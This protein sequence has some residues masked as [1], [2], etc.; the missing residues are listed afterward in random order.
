MSKLPFI[1][2]PEKPFRK[3]EGDFYE[4]LPEIDAIS[5]ERRTICEADLQEF[6]TTPGR[7]ALYDAIMDKAEA[8]YEQEMI[9]RIE[10]RNHND[11]MERKEMHR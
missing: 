2:W 9:E 1:E 11:K 5:N 4:G 10:R 6:A 8:Q 3:I 7:Q